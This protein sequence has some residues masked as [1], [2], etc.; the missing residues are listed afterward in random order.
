MLRSKDT[1]IG[2]ISLQVEGGVITR[3]FLPCESVDAPA[4]E[5]GSLS[6]HAFRQLDEFL[7]GSRTRFDL[8]LA[9]PAGTPLQCRLAAAIASIPYGRTATYASIGPARVAGSVCA[10]NPLPLFIPC[11]RVI[12]AWNPPGQYRGGSALKAWLLNMEN[13]HAGGT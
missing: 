7:A 11:H 3:L 5:P 10:R 1:I 12:P 4:P 13:S 8:P 6:E 9:P 2:R